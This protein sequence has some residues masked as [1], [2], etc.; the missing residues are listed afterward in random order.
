MKRDRGEKQRREYV[1]KDIRHY[2]G[3]IAILV[4][5]IL[6]FTLYRVCGV[7]IFYA[8]KDLGLSFAYYVAFIVDKQD[9]ITPSVNT[10]IDVDIQK[11]MEFSMVALE[12]KVNGYWDA[13][14]DFGN[15]LEY[16]IYGVNVLN[17]FTTFL[18]CLPF[19]ALL[20]YLVFGK[21][22]TEHVTDKEYKFIKRLQLRVVNIVRK[23][24]DTYNWLKEYFS[25]HK[26]YVA[27]FVCLWLMNTNLMT[28]IVEFFAWYFYV[29]VSFD[30]LSI[31]IQLVKLC[32]DVIISLWTLPLFLWSIIGYKVFDFIRRSAAYDKL[33]H[34]EKKNRGF[35]N[36]LP[37]CSMAV[38]SMGVGKT[39]TVVDMSL[40]F[41]NQFKDKS[42]ELMDANMLR[43]PSFNFQAFEKDLGDKIKQ[44]EVINLASA[45]R[46]VRELRFKYGRHPVPAQLW[47]YDVGKYPRSYNNGLELI[48][49]WRVLENYAQEYFIYT[50]N[51][52]LIVS[53]LAIRGDMDE[54]SYGYFVT[55]N[56]DFFKRDPAKLKEHSAYAHII[57]FDLFRIGCQMNK[58]NAIAG[59][60]EF[61]VIV[62]TEIGKERQN[63]VELK[64]TK[65]NT[66]EANQKNDLFN[67]WLKMIRHGGTVEG[68]CFVRF[69]CDEQRA[70]SWGA[71]ARDLVA[72]LDIRSI[73]ERK[74]ALRF[75]ILP[76]LFMD[77]FVKKYTAWYNKVKTYGNENCYFVYTLH[78]IVGKIFG[79]CERKFNIFGYYTEIINVRSGNLEDDTAPVEHKYYLM[80]KK[81]YAGRYSTDCFKDT[82]A[83][84]ALE[85]GTS[86]YYLPTYDS[87]CAKLEELKKQNSYMAN[88]FIAMYLNL[89]EL[90]KVRKK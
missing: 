70:S 53:N 69:I 68:Y 18:L 5:T 3:L 87:A 33:N 76:A 65:K 21:Y 26:A 58:E 51:V 31:G 82:F 34:M 78:T 16:L 59:S 35:D 49:I 32:S 52:S 37:I 46:Y 41:Q 84:R 56:M 22:T 8:V 90:M 47:G 42:L 2:I 11:Y 25:E 73:S 88:T 24:S 54:I 36:E 57:D 55:F 44:S 29:F 17:L 79:S 28:V 81:I 64:E 20:F 86:L 77:N 67:Y 62:V 75:C 72:L 38:G 71:D 10:V 27:V 4:S 63:S 1:E 39:K 15:F 66:D 83:I 12:R 30:F 74:M 23:I 48:G 61:G 45:R 13:F 89:P 43:F 6:F 9:L 19:F 14:W 50:M 60:F 80:P 7:R 40:S 85:A